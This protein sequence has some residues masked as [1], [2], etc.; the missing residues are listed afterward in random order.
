MKKCCDC[1]KL[2]YPEYPGDLF[3]DD[4]L[5]AQEDDNFDWDEEKG[6]NGSFK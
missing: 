2:F 3:C 4:C 5:D 6:N 1:G